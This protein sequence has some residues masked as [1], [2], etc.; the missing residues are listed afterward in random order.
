MPY[1]EAA[2]SDG[3]PAHRH[4]GNN[5]Q[6]SPCQESLPEGKLMFD[7]RCGI[8]EPF[9]RISIS[10]FISIYCLY[11]YLYLYLSLYLYLY[12]SVLDLCIYSYIYIYIYIYITYIYTWLCLYVLCI[13]MIMCIIYIYV[14]RT[15]RGIWGWGVRENGVMPPPGTQ[16]IF[17][18][19][20]GHFIS[21]WNGGSLFWDDTHVD[22]GE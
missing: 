20:T 14:Q 9:Y 13:Y 1:T 4:H 22:M 18:W 16:A 7:I 17:W 21:G 15:T 5:P 3:C 11:L 10:I 19:W 12:L 8:L 6:W 2:T